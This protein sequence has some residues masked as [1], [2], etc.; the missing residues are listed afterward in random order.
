[1]IEI[2]GV[3][4]FLSSIIKNFPN[5]LSEIPRYCCPVET[6]YF[7]FLVLLRGRRMNMELKIKKRFRGKQCCDSDGLHLFTF[8]NN[9]GPYFYYL[10][11]IFILLIRKKATKKLIHRV[12]NYPDLLP[13][14]PRYCCPLVI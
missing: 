4:A 11:S 1:M 12:G 7:G 6:F 9:C 10:I 14:M 2:V 5:P 8:I 3:I 13:E